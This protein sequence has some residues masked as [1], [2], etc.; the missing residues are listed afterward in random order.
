VI[1]GWWK[2]EKDLLIFPAM[3]LGQV[4]S[5]SRASNQ[6]FLSLSSS[7]HQH[8]C[9]AQIIGTRG[10]YHWVVYMLD[11]HL[12]ILRLHFRFV[13]CCCVSKELFVTG[14]FQSFCIINRGS[15]EGW[16]VGDASARCY[17]TAS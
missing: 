7:L 10:I 4:S 12:F 14:S 13:P 2:V 16:L 3:Q 8:D 9:N 6:S 11:K 15:G 5:E 1:S 17:R